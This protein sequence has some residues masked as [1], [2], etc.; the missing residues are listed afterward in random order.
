[1]VRALPV[2]GSGAV[3]CAWLAQPA[4]SNEVVSGN[5]VDF[6]LVFPEAMAGCVVR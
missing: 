4:M 3:N 1:V 6:K 2:E 5:Q